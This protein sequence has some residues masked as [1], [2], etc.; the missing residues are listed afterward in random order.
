MSTSVREI[1]RAAGV[2]KPTLY[3]YFGSKEGLVR[4]LVDEA[5]DEFERIIDHD[6][7]QAHNAQDA[8]IGL[9]F[10]YFTF[11]GQRPALARF[12]YSLIFG[13]AGET[14]GVDVSDLVC[15]NRMLMEKVVDR[16]VGE[17]LIGRDKA[18]MARVL[19]TGLVNVHIMGFIKGQ[20][21][22]LDRDLA[23]RAVALYLEGAGSPTH[24]SRYGDGARNPAEQRAGIDE[25]KTE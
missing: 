9:V 22:A 6:L 17:G 13:P 4:A 7:G 11:C 23:V 16:A 5:F 25:R 1:V 8:I 18:D 24:Q 21:R 2:T 3:Y 19:L 14:T 15:R 20:V 12:L 10:S